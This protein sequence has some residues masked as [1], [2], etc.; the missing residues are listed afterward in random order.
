[1]QTV[2]RREVLGERIALNQTRVWMHK[3]CRG[4]RDAGINGT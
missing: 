4:R 1:M 2:W 3:H